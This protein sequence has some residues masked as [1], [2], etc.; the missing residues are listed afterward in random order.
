MEGLETSKC[1]RM[2]SKHVLGTIIVDPYTRLPNQ[3]LLSSE[4]RWFLGK[5][6][7]LST[8][9]F[10]NRDLGDEWGEMS[11]KWWKNDEKSWK[12]VGKKL[13][14]KILFFVHICVLTCLG[15]V[16]WR[17]DILKNDFPIG[18]ELIFHQRGSVTRGISGRGR[19]RWSRGRRVK[20]MEKCWKKQ[21]FYFFIFCSDLYPGMPGTDFMMFEYVKMIFG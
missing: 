15:C 9:T 10:V 5:A 19:P 11:E 3:L 18:F 7:T 2:C 1:I 4:I 20:M 16:L 8:V 17:L 13:K 6:T 12:K 14:N 21:N